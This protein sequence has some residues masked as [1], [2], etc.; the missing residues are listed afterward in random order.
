VNPFS[1]GEPVVGTEET[2]NFYAV[3][4]TQS[5]DYDELHFVVRHVVGIHEVL[6][7]EIAHDDITRYELLT[8]F[9]ESGARGFFSM[10]AQA[11]TCSMASRMKSL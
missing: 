6:R 10:A 7:A 3:L 1:L 2:A 9:G 5:V 8:K 4:V 11:A